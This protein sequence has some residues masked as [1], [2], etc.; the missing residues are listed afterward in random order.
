VS[1][2]DHLSQR[3]CEVFIPFDHTEHFVSLPQ[4]P[5]LDATPAHLSEW[6][7]FAEE[8]S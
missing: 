6:P 1:L 3:L 2:L 8:P 5:F 4:R 7:K